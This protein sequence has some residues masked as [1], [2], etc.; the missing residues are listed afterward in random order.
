MCTKY[1]YKYVCSNTCKY[2][3]RKTEDIY[4]EMKPE[5]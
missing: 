1:V 5:K 4:G 3:A 2:K